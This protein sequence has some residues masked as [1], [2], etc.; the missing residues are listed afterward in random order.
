MRR[1]EIKV[2]F[3]AYLAARGNEKVELAH[4]LAIELAGY[5]ADRFWDR[6]AAAGLRERDVKGLLSFLDGRGK[7]RIRRGRDGRRLYVLTLRELRKNP[8]KLDEWLRPRVP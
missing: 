2:L 7:L 6:V 8:V 1:K 3:K 5:T 4:R